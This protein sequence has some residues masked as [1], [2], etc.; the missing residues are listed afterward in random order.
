MAFTKIGVCATGAQRAL[1]Q[2]SGADY[3][4]EHVQQ[5]LAPQIGNTE[6]MARAKVQP[7]WPQAMSANC[8]LPGEIKVV[9]PAADLSA[10][11]DYAR[12]AFGRARQVGIKIIVF[13]SSG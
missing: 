13:G 6:F 8:F 10:L 7:R 12:T 5:F 9:G 11:L 4:E 1:L 3:V 2:A